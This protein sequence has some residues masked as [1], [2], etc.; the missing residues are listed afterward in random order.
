M[1]RF[2]GLDRPIVPEDQRAYMLSLFPFVD[3]I[4]VFDEDTP[5]KL[6]EAIRPDVLVKG[7]DY[8]RETTVG[9]EF[10]ESYG[11][12]VAIFPRLE[13]LSTTAMLSKFRQV[14]TDVPDAA[15]SKR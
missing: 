7:G 5:M 15:W 11:G 3:L 9:S 4:V 1:R 13:G 10:V 14:R 2:K 12:R 6:V 8:T